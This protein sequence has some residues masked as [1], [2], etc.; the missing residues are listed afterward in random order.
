MTLNSNVVGK[1]LT[2]QLWYFT[3][4]PINAEYM[5][6]HRSTSCQF[7]ISCSAVRCFAVTVHA[8]GSILGDTGKCGITKEWNEGT[9]K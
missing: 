8:F 4:W 6:K 5:F 7:N 1:L 9:T 2:F 3:L